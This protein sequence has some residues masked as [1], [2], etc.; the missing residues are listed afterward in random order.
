MWNSYPNKVFFEL[1]EHYKD[2]IIIEIAGDDNF[3][4]TRYH[5]SQDIL[6]SHE[7]EE[8]NL[9][10]NMLILPSMTPWDK[11]NPAI[12]S[13]EVANDTLIPHN[14]KALYLNLRPT[15][16]KRWATSFKK[17]EFREMDVAKDFGLKDLT[18]KSIDEFRK[19]L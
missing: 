17:L 16:N 11:N 9:Y 10:H 12:S 1:I 8:S 19:R 14:Y 15:M 5:T 4:S 18:S 13:L 2:R 6:D 7:S 3:M